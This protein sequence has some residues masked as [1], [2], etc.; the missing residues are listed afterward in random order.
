MEKDIR[1]IVID[2]S[3]LESKADGWEEEWEKIQGV[4]DEEIFLQS[5]I[6]EV[7]PDTAKER[8]TDSFYMLYVSCCNRFSLATVQ[9][10][11]FEPKQYTVDDFFNGSNLLAWVNENNTMG[12]LKIDRKLLQLHEPYWQKEWKKI[13]YVFKENAFLKSRTCRIISQNDG[14]SLTKDEILS[15]VYQYCIKR[16]HDKI[17]EPPSDIECHI[18]LVEH[19]FAPM[20]IKRYSQKIT[21]DPSLSCEL[22]IKDEFKKELAKKNNA[23]EQEQPSAVN[24]ILGN[25]NVRGFYGSCSSD[26]EN[27]ESIE[28]E[29][30]DEELERVKEDT[31]EEYE[32]TIWDIN[33]TE[34]QKRD[35]LFKEKK[36]DLVQALNQYFSFPRFKEKRM[37]NTDLDFYVGVQLYKHYNGYV[38]L[39]K[40]G[41]CYLRSGTFSIIEKCSASENEGL[42]PHDRL[43]SY[44][45][46]GSAILRK[47]M[48][49]LRQEDEKKAMNGKEKTGSNLYQKRKKEETFL[50]FM[51]NYYP[52]FLEAWL[53]ELGFT[54]EVA[55]QL[56]PTKYITFLGKNLK[57][58][59]KQPVSGNMKLLEIIK[60]GEFEETEKNL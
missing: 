40:A 45:T 21:K 23:Q 38:V 36:E 30:T 39:D 19:M 4:F 28:F 29:Y 35:A 33:E 18:D 32:K 15:N 1:N 37:Q 31:K 48:N 5:R 27:K 14:K 11:Q 50:S 42:S 26:D 10:S 56:W 51:F 2:M 25:P 44:F 55:A 60:N 43:H 17:T 13:E 54:A 52:I 20:S 47:H 12:A 8:L 41:L 57:R 7:F 16:W 3:K 9:E 6:K 53:C 49:S 24:T 22:N 58:W 34:K 46:Q 59:K